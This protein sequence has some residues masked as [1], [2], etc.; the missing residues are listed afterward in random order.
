MRRDNTGLEIKCFSKELES[1]ANSFKAECMAKG[2]RVEVIGC[3]E[4]YGGTTWSVDDVINCLERDFSCAY[5]IPRDYIEGFLVTHERSLTDAAIEN[6][7]EVI[8]GSMDELAARRD[9]DEEEFYVGQRV[10]IPQDGAD[11][12]GIPAEAEIVGFR[13]VWSEPDS[14]IACFNKRII[15]FA[16]V[17]KIGDEQTI[18]I[19][20]DCISPAV[21]SSCS[22][23]SPL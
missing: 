17:Q 14:G 19:L 7:W 16:D 8:S 5:K 12:S 13:K 20:I 9:S 2:V 1:L 10:L 3:S 18:S 15:T 21:E 6:G 11:E 22:D 4:S 23:A